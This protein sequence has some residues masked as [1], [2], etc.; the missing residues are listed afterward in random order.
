[1][2]GMFI[3]IALERQVTYNIEG[4]FIESGT[5]V[6]ESIKQPSIWSK[7][8]TLPRCQTL[9]Y[10]FCRAYKCPIKTIFQKKP[11]QLIIKEGQ[12]IFWTYN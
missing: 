3:S 8:V 2:L 4:C 1:M 11:E 6:P 7:I 9:E 10:T 5:E 12:L